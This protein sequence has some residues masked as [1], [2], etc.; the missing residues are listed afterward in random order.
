MRSLAQ[1]R[2]IV[3]HHHERLDGS[4][5]PDALRGDQIPPLAQIVGIVDTFDA[6]TTTR[7]YR[8]ARSFDHGL[9]ELRRDAAKGLF[10]TDLVEAFC[11]L[12]H[13]MLARTP[14]SRGGGASNTAP[15]NTSTRHGVVPLVRGDLG[16]VVGS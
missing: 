13:S 2:P 14:E 3:R 4:G 11:A 5:Y 9:T 1:V 10:P 8:A 6:V 16:R 7:P 12:D 15:G